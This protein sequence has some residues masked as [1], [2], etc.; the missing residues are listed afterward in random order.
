MLAVCRFIHFLNLIASLIISIRKQ[1]FF[2]I[3]MITT[4]VTV[5]V[6]IVTKDARSAF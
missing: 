6:I 4:S 5:T 2:S 3:I 1:C